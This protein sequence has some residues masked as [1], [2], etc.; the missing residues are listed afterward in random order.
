M[1]GFNKSAFGELVARCGCGVLLLSIV[2]L[3]LLSICD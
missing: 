2:L 3:F 1:S